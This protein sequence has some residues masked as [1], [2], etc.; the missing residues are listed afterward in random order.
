MHLLPTTGSGRRSPWTRGV[1]LAALFAVAAL[2]TATSVAAQ[3]PTTAVDPVAVV[4]TTSTTTA[5]SDTTSP[6]STTSTTEATTSTTSET[7]STTES[8]ESTATTATTTPTDTTEPEP[9]TT[10][11]PRPATRP[12][13]QTST[14]PVGSVVFAGAVLVAVAVLVWMALRRAPAP[15][16]A[17]PRRTAEEPQARPAAESEA[18]GPVVDAPVAVPGS[19]EELQALHFLLEMGQA[20]I[21]AGESSA[22]T[23]QTLEDIAEVNGIFGLGAV[24]LPTALILSVPHG[25]DVQTEVRTAGTS[26]L[27]MDQSDELF[28]LVRRAER[29][30][31]TPLEGLAAIARA[32]TLPPRFSPPVRLLG[33]TIFTVGLV[34]LLRGSWADLL[35]GAVLGVGVGALQIALARTT[36]RE[37]RNYQAFWPLLAAFTVTVVVLALGRVWS[38]LSVFAPLVAPLVTFLPGGLLTTGVLELSSG[39]VISGAGRLAS[40]LMQLVLL[41]LGIVAGAQLVGF[42]AS[43]I[44]ETPTNPLGVAAAWLGVAVFGFGVYVF[45]GARTESL[46]W[47]LLVLYVAY[48]GQVIGGL[49]F[50]GTL[51]AFFG[52]VAMT[53]I[54]M[55]AARQEDGPAMLV[56]FLPGFWLLVPGALGLEGITRIFGDDQIEGISAMVTTVATMVGVSLGVLLGLALGSRIPALNRPAWADRVRA[57]RETRLGRAARVHHPGDAKDRG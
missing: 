51:S 57:L 7:T 40:G 50:G 53:P 10:L 32:R 34:L 47:I 27:T 16:P 49:F 9:T 55:L 1:L 33:A 2:G 31:V 5:R 28:R 30:E 43:V 12:A 39:H 35:L 18:S 48:A 6:T 52:A 13:V 22:N 54:A 44:G 23:A 19:P 4:E 11:E 26:K 25:T 15:A 37:I 14:I 20:L 3:E 36:S 46:R 29:G 17:R 56:S 8:P 21:D 24:V 41:A 45:Y 42:P 38:D